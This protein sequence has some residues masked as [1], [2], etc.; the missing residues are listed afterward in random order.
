MRRGDAIAQRA[1]QPRDRAVGDARRIGGHDAVGA[2][3]VAGLVGEDE[4]LQRARQQQEGTRIRHA[5]TVAS[6]ADAQPLHAAAG[7]GRRL[8]G[9]E[10]AVGGAGARHAAA[11]HARAHARGLRRRRDAADVHHPRVDPA[12]LRPRRGVRALLLPDAEDERDRLARTTTATVLL[13]TTRRRAARRR[14]RRPAERAAARLRGRGAHAD[15][16][17]SGCGRSRTSRSPTRCCASRSAG[18]R[19]SSRRCATCC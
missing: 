4:P 16:A 7:G 14:A 5:R 9:V 8:P 18:A 3:Q 17:C 12:A 15:R 11:L 2:Q 19:T 10:R 6:G 13:V 1:G